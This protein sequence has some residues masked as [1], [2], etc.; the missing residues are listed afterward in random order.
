MWTCNRLFNA[1]ETVASLYKHK[2][3]MLCA[4][5]FTL[6]ML[7]DFFFFPRDRHTEQKKNSQG[8]NTARVIYRIAGKFGGELN[9]AIWQSARTTVKLKSTKISY[10]R[11]YVWRFR[12]KPPNLNLPICLQRQFGTQPP[13]LVCSTTK[14][15]IMLGGYVPFAQLKSALM[16][17]I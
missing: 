2:G 7:L 12:T 13:N 11:I 9:L 17:K 8:H 3:Q 5:G 16:G 15:G 10:S 4:E 6:Y 1:F 14:L